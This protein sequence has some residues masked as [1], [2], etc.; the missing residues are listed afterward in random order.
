MAPAIAVM[1]NHL[2]GLQAV[3]LFLRALV[4]VLTIIQDVEMVE[5][6]KFEDVLSHLAKRKA[7]L[8]LELHAERARDL[9]LSACDQEILSENR[10]A[11][12]EQAYVISQAG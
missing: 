10:S 5:N 1:E 6:S 4:S 8:L 9:E 2:N 12:V 11:V 7:E 3:R